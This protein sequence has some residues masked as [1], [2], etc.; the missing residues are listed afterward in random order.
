MMWIFWLMIVM[1]NVMVFMNFTIAVINDC[2]GEI[3]E[4]REEE[5]YQKK[6]GILCELEGVFGKFAKKSPTSILVTRE[7]LNIESA[8]NEVNYTL[9]G[10]KKQWLVD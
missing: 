6:C 8:D 10:L 3:I 5:A 4:T 1:V 2:Y 9:K 7:S